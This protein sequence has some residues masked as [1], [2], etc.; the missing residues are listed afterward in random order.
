MYTAPPA[1]SVLEGVDDDVLGGRARQE[2]NCAG[3][4]ENFVEKPY[5]V[6]IVHQ[7]V[8]STLDFRQYDS[9][10]TSSN[11]HRDKIDRYMIRI[12]FI[13]IQLLS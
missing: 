13:I 2:E 8:I 1:T 7:F 11:K 5:G 4:G 9:H 3:S 6:Q 12:R 10:A